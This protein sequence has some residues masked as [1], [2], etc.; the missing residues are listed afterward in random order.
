MGLR[1]FAPRERFLQNNLGLLG[2]N[3][4]CAGCGPRSLAK[5]ESQIAGSNPLTDPSNKRARIAIAHHEIAG[6]LGSLRS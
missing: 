6:S 2:A 1:A 3:L 4:P 5:G